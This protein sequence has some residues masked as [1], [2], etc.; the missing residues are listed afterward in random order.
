MLNRTLNAIPAKPIVFGRRQWLDRQRL[1]V[2]LAAVA[3]WPV[4][5]ALYI[6]VS[7]VAGK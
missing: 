1:R 6:G 7:A 3:A 2:V 4:L 5:I